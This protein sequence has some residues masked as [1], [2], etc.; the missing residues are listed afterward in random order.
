A[1]TVINSG[2]FQEQLGDIRLLQSYPRIMYQIH[3][4]FLDYKEAYNFLELAIENELSKKHLLLY[5]LLRLSKIL[6][7]K[8]NFVAIAEKTL[9]ISTKKQNIVIIAKVYNLLARFYL[10]NQMFMEAQ[11]YYKKYSEF[12]LKSILPTQNYNNIIECY[13]D[14]SNFHYEINEYKKSYEYLLKSHDIISQHKDQISHDNIVSFY[15]NFAL[16]LDN[17]DYL[18]KSIENLKKLINF[19]EISRLLYTNHSYSIVTYSVLGR[20]YLKKHLYDKALKYTKLSIKALKSSNGV[21]FSKIRLCS[22][23]IDLSK[24]YTCQFMFKEALKYNLIVKNFFQNDVIKEKSCLANYYISTSDLYNN[25]DNIKQA[26][27]YCRKALTKSKEVLNKSN[28]AK[29]HEFLASIS[30]KKGKYTEALKNFKLAL[31]IYKETYTFNK[32]HQRIISCDIEI[33]EIYISL[34]NYQAAS[35]IISESIEL[36]QSE[37]NRISRLLLGKLYNLLGNIF[38]ENSKYELALYHYKSVFEIYQQQNLTKTLDLV[39]LYNDIGSLYFEQSEYLKATDSYDKAFKILKDIYQDNLL[40]LNIAR[41]YNNIAGIKSKQKDFE[42]ALGHY[43][44]ALNIYQ[45][46]YGNDNHPNIA[47][48]YYHLGNIYAEQN[49]N[50]LSLANYQIYFKISKNLGLSDE[51]ENFALYR[52][53]VGNVLKNK[54]KYQESEQNY[55]EAIELYK[56]IFL[57]NRLNKSLFSV[58]NNL[59]NLYIKMGLFKKSLD[60]LEKS[61]CIKK[62][63]YKNNLCNDEIAS[64]YNNLG[65]LFGTA[66][67]YTQAFRFYNLALKIYKVV[68]KNI[69]H[70]EIC[71][72][73]GRLGSI[74]LYQKSYME[75]IKYYRYSL[76]IQDVIYEENILTQRVVINYEYLAGS[77]TSLGQISQ[78]QRYFLY[79]LLIDQKRFGDNF[80]RSC[81]KRYKNLAI[82]SLIAGKL[83][84]AINYFETVLKIYRKIYKNN[85]LNPELIQ[86]LN[87]LDKAYK[88]KGLYQKSITLNEERLNYVISHTEENNQIELYNI[89]MELA[90]GYRDNRK[91]DEA[92]NNYLTVLD[93]FHNATIANKNIYI[94]KIYQRLSDIYLS[95]QNYEEAIKYSKLA[96]NDFVIEMVHISKGNYEFLKGNQDKTIHYYNSCSLLSGNLE[97]NKLIDTIHKIQP[98]YIKDCLKDNRIPT[99]ILCKKVMLRTDPELA[100]GNHYYDLA[101]LFICH[102]QIKEAHETFVEY[103]NV[104]NYAPKANF[105]AEYAQFIILNQEN[106]ANINIEI[107]GEKIVEV[108]YQVMIIK[109][110]SLLTYSALEKNFIAPKLQSIIEEKIAAKIFE[111]NVQPNVLAYYLVVKNIDTINPKLSSNK[112]LFMK[113]LEKICENNKDKISLALLD[114]LKQQGKPINDDFDSIKQD[115]IDDINSITA[116]EE[117][118]D[119]AAL[120]QEILNCDDFSLTM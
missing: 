52:N 81:F 51:H 102:G 26:E 39:K 23:Y 97:Q 19:N 22:A 99:A 89:Y 105:L 74:C 76:K 57:D 1:V 109:D 49:N 43:Q 106:L 3:A 11:N 48:C 86:I 92:L 120:K 14:L 73:Y 32:K 83:D 45:K 15:W 20:V 9:E 84:S 82:I 113:R 44:K 63:I 90:D 95:S 5:E 50:D 117:L 53:S 10:Y 38:R 69:F 33:A 96:K 35:K 98:S 115:I 65:S 37:N 101:K 80:S 114:D 30:K 67:N 31:N 91:Y 24:I 61:L 12:V 70:K 88:Q 68:S 54:G 112:P 111:V 47:R 103:M 55:L 13:Y 110:Q 42:N 8:Q 62:Q 58:Y 56:K 87:N 85:L 18:D 107:S 59:G 100:R 93:I 60:C 78:A 29:G 108:L 28:I 4:K 79:S 66:G 64:S 27:Y 40:V 6:G 34:N 71:E 21:T 77:Y 118:I 104:K 7:Y 2:V 119:L 75:A 46:I 16:F 94:N 72:I 17:Q 116:E 41:Y 25:M 36:L